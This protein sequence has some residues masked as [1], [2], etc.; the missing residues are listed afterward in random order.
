MLTRPEKVWHRKCSPLFMLDPI[1]RFDYQYLITDD[2]TLHAAEIVA[3]LTESGIDL[4]AFSEF[5][6]GPGKLQVDL[7]TKSGRSLETVAEEMGWKLSQRKPVFLIQGEDRPNAI[8]RILNRLAGA[9][10]RVTAMQAVAAGAGRFGALLWVEAP[11]VER[12][13]LMLR[14]A[15]LD[16]V[17]E[18][19]E[20]SFPASDPPAWALSAAR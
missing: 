10:I 3:S 13:T 5:P 14:E 17:D 12:T 9:D 19:S 7:I 20:E 1:E 16:P 2:R 6:R 11:E 18:S 15:I 4:L 8:G